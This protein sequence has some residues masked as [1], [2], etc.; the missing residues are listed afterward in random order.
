MSLDLGKYTEPIQLQVGAEMLSGII[1]RTDPVKLPD[2]VFL[3]GAGTGNYTRVFGM[4]PA[5]IENGHSIL[6]FDFSG[7]GKS[8]GILKESSLQKRTDEA[9]SMIQEFAS[10]ESPLTICGSSMGGYIALKMLAYFPE[11]IRNLVLFCPGVYDRRAFD[12]R[13]NSGFTEQIRVPDSWKNSDVFALLDHFK[14]NLA[15]FI[16][17]KDQVIPPAVIDLIDLHAANTAKKQIVRIPDG[18]HLIHG[19]LLEHPDLLDRVNR[20]IVEMMEQN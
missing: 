5:L 19:W 9:V 2:F 17:E 16:G 15:V 8:S 6:A 7:H 10:R 4:A 20:A 1:L 18:P 12:L 3:H 13:F 11:R 14:G